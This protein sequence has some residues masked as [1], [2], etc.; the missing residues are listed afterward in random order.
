MAKIIGYTAQPGMAAMGQG[1]W[2]SAGAAA[3]VEPLKQ[4]IDKSVNEKMLIGGIAMTIGFI[5][6]GALVYVRTER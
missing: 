4:H 5:A 2:L 6:I 3:M 1:D